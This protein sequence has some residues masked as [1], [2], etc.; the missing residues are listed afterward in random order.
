MLLATAGCG[1]L[2][3]AE[4]VRLYQQAR[5]Q[6]A[7]REFQGATYDDPGNADAYYNLAMTY[8]QIG[9]LEHRQ[10]DLQ[11]AECYPAPTARSL[12]DPYSGSAN[13]PLTVMR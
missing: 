10:A 12:A 2:R 4:G 1:D 6:D 13:R 7:L 5:Y 8:H 11:Q 3:N 9:R